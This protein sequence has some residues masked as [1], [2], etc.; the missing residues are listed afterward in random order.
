[1]VLEERTYTIKPGQIPTLLAIYEREGLSAQ[2][3]HL[4]EPVGWFTSEFGLL[5]QVVHMWR[6][7]SLDDR[8]A[9]R[10]AALSGDPEWQAF[11]PKALE[12]IE[13]QENRIL[14]PTKFSPMR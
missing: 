3:R 6:F 5:N 12:L 7:E 13:K 11:V 4:G 1:M 14:L 9:K 10:R 8:C 2:R